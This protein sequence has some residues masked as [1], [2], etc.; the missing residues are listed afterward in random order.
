M[1]EDLEKPLVDP[2]NFNREGIDV[3][4][5]KSSNANTCKTIYESIGDPI[6]SVFSHVDSL[7]KES[8]L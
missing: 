1:P 3:E 2:N 4:I 6:E 5:M 7:N 8:A